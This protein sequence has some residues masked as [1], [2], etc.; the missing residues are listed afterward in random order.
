[1]LDWLEKRKKRRAIV[2]DIDDTISKSFD[3]PIEVA[4]QLL[5]A[6]DRNIEV[7]YVTSRPPSS[8]AATESYFEAHR[9]PGAMNIHFCPEWKSSRLHKA[10]ITKRIAVEFNLLACIGD[11]DED[12]QAAREAEVRFIRVTSAPEEAWGE[13][14]ELLRDIAVN[15]A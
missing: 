7:H 12:E 2:C 5:C 15:Q 10:E 6:I 9:L 3:Q 4:C 13:M 11:A 8:R 1:M 14:A